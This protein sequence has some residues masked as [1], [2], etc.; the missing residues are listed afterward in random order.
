[1]VL[2]LGFLIFSIYVY[3]DETPWDAW[4]RDG[5]SVVLFDDYHTKE[6]CLIS[7][8]GLDNPYACSFKCNLPKKIA[9]VAF[10]GDACEKIKLEEAQ[11]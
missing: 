10:D 11:N 6:A 7:L 1:M 4:Q 2:P 3:E 9:K 5:E 8:K